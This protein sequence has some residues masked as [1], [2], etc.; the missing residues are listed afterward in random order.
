MAAPVLPGR[1]L[2]RRSSRQLLLATQE[3]NFQSASKVFLQPWAT[4]IKPISTPA[5]KDTGRETEEENIHDVS[6][7]RLSGKLGCRP[8]DD[9][10][11]AL[12]PDDVTRYRKIFAGSHF[13][14]QDRM[15]SA[16]ATK[17]ATRRV[18]APNKD[19]AGK[20]P[21]TMQ[22]SHQVVACFGS[23]WAGCRRTWRS[24]SG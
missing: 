6:K 23:D 14:A 5:A 4:V 1:N 17:E 19:Q 18:T 9:D 22:D 24:T 10:V 12:S 15:D 3:S 11:D 2:D 8:N 13:L 7:R 21:C 16:L 20:I